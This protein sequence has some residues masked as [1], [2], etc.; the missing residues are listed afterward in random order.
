MKNVFNRR[1]NHIVMHKD[2]RC[3]DKLDRI[4]KK[5]IASK[6][7]RIEMKNCCQHQDKSYR[8]DKLLSASGQIVS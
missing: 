7:N 1:T 4:T 2:G 8:N 5:L 6:T 3:M